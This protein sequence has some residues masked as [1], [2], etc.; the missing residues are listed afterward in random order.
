M[1]FEI[2]PA[3]SED[4]EHIS[5][6]T[7]DTFSWGDYVPDRLPMWLGDESSTV[8]VAT[9]DGS[10]KAMVHAVILSPFEGWLEAA[11]VHPDH[12][13]KGLGRALNRA[14]VGW[15]AKQ[16]VRVVR[17][18]T[19]AA[20][21]PAVTQI[22]ALDYRQTS[23]WTYADVRADRRSDDD[24]ARNFGPATG[25]DVDAA[26]VFWS[27]SELNRASRG[28]ISRGWQWRTAT[29]A[30]LVSGATSGHFLQS[31]DGWVLADQPDPKVLR[32]LWMATTPEDAPRF[33]EG[34]VDRAW[35]QDAE[36]VT[37]KAPN[38]PWM[39]EAIRRVGGDPKEIL[40]FSKSV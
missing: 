35:S 24:D 26:W 12:R 17:L 18:A 34:V 23:S 8:L 19:E 28:L 1:V 13:R 30:D 4:V 6:W 9:V 2:R 7:S 39:T 15:L 14:C 5:S 10:P 27:S 36:S 22:L 37:V 16:G 11:R 29:P 20:N 33:L 25:S 38:V 31:P 40:I 3:H 32:V 21:Q